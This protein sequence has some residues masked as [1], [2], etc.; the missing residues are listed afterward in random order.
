[1]CLYIMYQTSW[2]SLVVT[3]GWY[4]ETSLS[5]KHT[6]LILKPEMG[7]LDRLRAIITMCSRDY[8]S[9]ADLFV[10]R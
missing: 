7:D 3:V 1:M 9:K 8:T 10:L 4:Y 6:K 2:Y 5:S